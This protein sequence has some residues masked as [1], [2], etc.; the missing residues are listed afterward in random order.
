MSTRSRVLGLALTL[1][2]LAFG[3]TILYTG[4]DSGSGN[5]GYLHV[6]QSSQPFHLSS[7][8]VL[9]SMT[10]STWVGGNGTGPSA[11]SWTFS[12]GQFGTGTVEASGSSGA[13]DTLN[14]IVGSFYDVY[15]TTGSLPNVDL[16]AGDYWLTLSSDDTSA[17]PWV[18][19]G[20]TSGAAFGGGQSWLGNNPVPTGNDFVLELDG[21]SSAPEPG[22]MGLMGLSVACIFALLRRR[23][24]EA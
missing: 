5:V 21:S 9:T 19:W 18:Y 22:T 23:H 15:N 7:E 16:K 2:S 14:F 20:A 24:S 4:P 10:I 13:S 11:L 8:S 3:G 12:G 1:G 6:G 17:F